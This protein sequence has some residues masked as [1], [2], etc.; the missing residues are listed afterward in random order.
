MPRYFQQLLGAALRHTGLSHL[1]IKVR[2]GP[3]GGF[4]WTLY[5]RT[6]YWR[7]SHEPEIARFVAAIP[8]LEG[9]TA[10]DL[11][12]HYGYYSLLLAAKVGATG[13]VDA[14]E[15]N[16]FSFRKL[17]RHA[18][19]NRMA[20]LRVHQAAVGA[21]ARTADMFSYRGSDDTGSHLA[22]T[23]ENTVSAPHSWQVTMLQ[24]DEEVAAGR[25]PPPAFIK[26]DVEGYG[27]HALTGA[28]ASIASTLPLIVAGLHSEEESTGIDNILLPLGY[29][30]GTVANRPIKYDTGQLDVVYRP[31]HP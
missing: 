2:R 11:G 21:S 18:E 22:Y 14:F 10:W 20:W 9:K 31:P 7:G 4:R 5:P 26:L 17:C 15:P 28:R 30:K 23:G 16:P 25:L 13:R 29:R 27:H 3:L 12:A 1:V 19:L 8:G 6:S 24:L